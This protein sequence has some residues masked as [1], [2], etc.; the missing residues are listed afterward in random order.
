MEILLQSISDLPDLVREL[1]VGSLG[2]QFRL[3]CHLLHLEETCD[4]VNSLCPVDNL[5]RL[6]I[7]DN[8]RVSQVLVL[9]V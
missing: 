8:I 7:E 2:G 6:N 3:V 4:I 9:Q 1:V 5:Q